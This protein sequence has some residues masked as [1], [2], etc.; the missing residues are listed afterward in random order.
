MKKLKNITLVMLF[1]ALLCV[2]PLIASVPMLLRL[3]AVGN[4]MQNETTVYF[5]ANGVQNAG[6]DPR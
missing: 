3:D 2:N 1:F 5:D 6:S 4:S